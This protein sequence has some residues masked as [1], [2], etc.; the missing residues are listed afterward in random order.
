[1]IGFSMIMATKEY[2]DPVNHAEFNLSSTLYN[3]TLHC[4]LSLFVCYAFPHWANN[5][6]VS[7]SSFASGYMELGEMP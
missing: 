3:Y 1:M 7:Y 4:V 2:G 5:R 6:N